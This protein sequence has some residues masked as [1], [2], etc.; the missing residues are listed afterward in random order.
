MKS[1]TAVDRVDSSA[2]RC[3]LIIG[4]V[5][6]KRTIKI[7]LRDNSI[8]VRLAGWFDHW[9][10]AF[11]TCTRYIVNYPT[12]IKISYEA[13]N[14]HGI[15]VQLKYKRIIRKTLFWFPS[16]GLQKY[17]LSVMVAPKI[18]WPRRH[19]WQIIF[20]NYSPQR[21]VRISMA[22]NPQGFIPRHYLY[23]I[24][25]H[26]FNVRVQSI[27]DQDSLTPG[28][29]SLTMACVHDDSWT[30]TGQCHRILSA[31]MGGEGG[32]W[33]CVYVE[34]IWFAHTMTIG[35]VTVY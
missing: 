11:P 28:E 25:D 23:I 17:P 35:A 8:W 13:L 32:F 18:R 10:V 2:S 16:P 9:V 30:R 33:T 27:I 15:F 5:H 7:F 3:L 29:F 22:V 31:T 26:R 24:V 6:V 1:T 14:S 20:P 19:V 12:T 4:L 21:C 34:Q